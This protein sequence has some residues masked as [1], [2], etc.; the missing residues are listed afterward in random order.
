MYSCN[1]LRVICTNC[2]NMVEQFTVYLFFI[3]NTR[4]FNIKVNSI[5]TNRKFI[6]EN[7]YITDV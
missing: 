3:N 7:D 5:T 4:R 1:Y 2:E 6:K